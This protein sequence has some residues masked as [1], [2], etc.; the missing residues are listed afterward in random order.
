MNEFEFRNKVK[1]I[2]ESCE[3]N[4][5][6]FCKAFD[7][8]HTDSKNS[9]RTVVVNIGFVYNLHNSNELT[10]EDIERIRY[11]AMSIIDLGIDNIREYHSEWMKYVEPDDYTI[12]TTQIFEF[13]GDA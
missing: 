4:G 2:Y 11:N 13:G 5:T 8:V 6:D 10:S 3:S 12:T 7:K 9:D 1:E